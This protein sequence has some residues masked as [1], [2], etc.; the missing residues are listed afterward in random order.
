L[1]FQWGCEGRVDSV[2]VDQLPL[3]GKAR[4]NMLAYGVEA[5]TQTTLDLLKKRQTLAQVEHAVGEAKKHGIA[6]VHGFFVIGCP[7][8]TAEDIQETFRFAARLELDTFGFNRLAVYRGTPLWS[9]YV[10]RG[11][12]DDDRDW[13]KTFKCCAID[14]D[15]VPNDEVN[16]LRMKGYGSLLLRRILVHPLRTWDLLRTFSRHMAWTDLLRLISG[17]FRTKTV[18][19]PDLPAA[20]VDAGLGAPVRKTKLQRI[21]N[22][23]AFSS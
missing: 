18:S 4:C 10:G 9:A 8:E 16:S 22:G 21:G 7:G 6:R 13:D 3:M 12:I 1:K 11:I 19:V 17:P 2:G 20:M 14:P 15:T 23:S 5:G